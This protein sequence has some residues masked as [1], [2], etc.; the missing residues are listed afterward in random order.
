MFAFDDPPA[1]VP[2]QK[3]VAPAGAA[4]T[5]IVVPAGAHDGLTKATGAGGAVATGKLE[6][7]IEED[8]IDHK[9][10]AV[11][12][13][14]AKYVPFAETVY[15]PVKAFAVLVPVAD[16]CQYQVTPDGEGP[17]KLI[18]VP[19]AQDGVPA[20]CVGVGGV[21]GGGVH[22]YVCP[23]AGKTVVDQDIVEPL[24]PPAAEAA[25]LLVVV[26]FE[27]TVLVAPTRPTCIV[28]EETFVVAP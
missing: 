16:V 10:A 7:T 18:V 9:F 6:T 3:Y 23:D 20:A 27:N 13:A 24:A 28:Q 19:V 21:P 8:A 1:F 4:A 17:A 26:L 22:V 14:R 25:Q 11:L 12:Y 2:C 15:G 5:E